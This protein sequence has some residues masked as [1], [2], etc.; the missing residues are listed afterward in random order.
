MEGRDEFIV[1]R[2]KI[3]KID[4]LK[5]KIERIFC[6][7]I[8][9]GDVAK[10]ENGSKQWITLSGEIED[11]RNAKQYIVGLCHPEVSQQISCNRSYV[12]DDVIENIEKESNAVIMIKPSENS[13]TCDLEIAGMD[14]AVTIALSLLENYFKEAQFKD[15]DTNN[16]SSSLWHEECSQRL[17]DGLGRALSQ[18]SDGCCSADDYSLLSDSVKRVI[19]HCLEKDESL[20]LSD[21]NDLFRTEDRVAGMC[22]S[23]NLYVNDFENLPS[24]VETD[25]VPRDMIQ[26]PTHSSETGADQVAGLTQQFTDANLSNTKTSM[27]DIHV[28]KNFYIQYGRSTGYSEEEVNEALNFVDEKTSPSDFLELLS[29]VKKVVVRDEPDT[30]VPLSSLIIEQRSPTPPQVKDLKPI[31]DFSSG[32]QQSLP[33]GNK[34]QPMKDLA[35]GNENS[36]VHENLMQWNAERQEKLKR[37]FQIQEE[38][39]HEAAGPGSSNENSDLQTYENGILPLDRLMPNIAKKKMNTKNNCN[40]KP[41]KRFKKG[42]MSAKKSK[43][44]CDGSLDAQDDDETCVMEVWS[45]DASECSQ[46]NKRN[47]F[48]Q[49]Q[50]MYS[51]QKKELV[52]RKAYTAAVASKPSHHGLSQERTPRYIVIDG[53]NVAMAHGNGKVFSCKG[54]RIC[55]DYF[56]KRGHDRITVFVPVWR[57]YKP[58]IEKSISQQHILNELKEEGYLVF[59]PGRRMATKTISC[60]D[61]RFVLELAEKEDGVIVSLDQYRD[62]V[63][64]RSSWQK[65]VDE[66]L[67]MY[68][69]AGDNFLP[70]EDPLGKDGPVLDDFLL[71]SSG[72][73]PSSN[74]NPPSDVAR[75]SERGVVS[76][77]RPVQQN[78]ADGGRGPQNQNWRQSNNKPRYQNQNIPKKQRFRTQKSTENLFLDLQR[79]FSDPNQEQTVRI[80]LDNHPEERDIE[81]LTNYCMS[82]LF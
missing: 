61:D 80:V 55:V 20:L 28:D 67:L 51:T 17:H 9:W 33:N 8:G 26:K 36:P 43:N 74:R 19:M 21:D 63:H 69:F 14:I 35:E 78:V 62:I 11:R 30:Y 54:I 15:L 65:V 32:L 46:G 25:A 64:E 68:C 73:S 31:E 1:A 23:E 47:N 53:S 71:K 41:Q 48:S 3:S 18:H 79:I 58:R 27:K 45:P 2:D 49:S 60:Y 16:H 4:A 38:K 34:M 76:P 52:P 39:L 50:V 82:V 57:S 22:E 44:S 77:G 6:V 70:P 59:T 56:L 29:R 5:S 66:R 42:K 7:D 81:R 10:V 37:E 75:K 12:I 13:N 72:T 24:E 40:S